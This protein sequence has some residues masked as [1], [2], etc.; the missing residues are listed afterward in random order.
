M[1]MEATVSDCGYGAHFGYAY[2]DFC[3]DNAP[4]ANINMPSSFCINDSVWFDAD[5]SLKET[6]YKV[7]LMACDSLGNIDTTKTA[8]QL[9]VGKQVG[10]YNLS[11][12]INDTMA[13]ID[14]I[15]W[16]CGQYYKLILAVGNECTPWALDSNVF[17][18][19]CPAKA[20]AG[21]DRCC[22]PPPIYLGDSSRSGYTYSWTPTTF[23]QSPSSYVTLCSPTGAVV[24]P[25]TYYLTVNAG[26]CQATDTVRV[27]CDPIAC[28]IIFDTSGCAN[29]IFFD[30]ANTTYSQIAWNI[31]DITISNSQKQTKTFVGDTLRYNPADGHYAKVKY[32][33]SNPCGSIVDSFTLGNKG[34]V[35]GD[36]MICGNAIGTNVDSLVI[37]E[38]HKNFGDSF[39]FGHATE[40]RIMVLGGW[41]SIF[42]WIA[43]KRQPD[44]YAAHGYGD[45]VY[46][47]RNGLF[48]GKEPI[49]VAVMRDLSGKVYII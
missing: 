39:T 46:G 21:P 13:N 18:I 19:T 48:I 36:T 16:E 15:K 32:T 20:L 35:S 3:T 2:F 40:W 17:S 8:T 28:S 37:Y 41:G 47:I 10:H 43:G 9:Y 24:Y 45:P 11:A 5:S 29:K 14:N 31:S 44:L 27:F 23:L 34:Y 4:T 22:D 1:I 26:S 6:M 12:L 42:S 49:I 30:G 38:K 25:L 7:N 33:I